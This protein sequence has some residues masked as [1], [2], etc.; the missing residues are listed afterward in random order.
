MLKKRDIIICFILG[1]LIFTGC[2]G[3]SVSKDDAIQEPVSEEIF[4]MDTYMTVTA[5]GK[6]AQDAV[7][8]AIE[9]IERLDA[10]LS[11]GDK[12]S[13]IS[14]LNDNGGGKV[15]DD[16][17]YLLNRS[18]ELWEETNGKFDITIYPI[19]L[20]WGFTDKNFTVPSNETLSQLLTL[21]DS[22]AINLNEN[23]S[24][25]TFEKEGLK[26][27]LGGIAKGYTSSRIMD[28]FRENGVTKGLVSLGG[29]VQVLG[30]KT[31]NDLW[32]VAIQNPD[33][34]DYLG[35]LQAEDC[36]VITSGG[37]ERYFEQDGITY[38]HIID[39]ATGYPANN[40]LKSVTIVSEDGTLADGLSTSLFIMGKDQAI[41]YWRKHIDEFDT[42]LVDDNGTIY[43]SEGI[44]D[45]FSSEQEIQIIKREG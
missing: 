23:K 16:T 29:N 28:I 5:Y 24:T 13:E 36:A 6:N 12:N 34:A 37:Y 40:G 30:R 20:S 25:V 26:I 42:I 17:K 45:R 22:S 14:S 19:M 27:D 33:G 4:A 3:E 38:H 8:K 31:D 35:V 11:T 41:D 43:V 9:E 21:V 44:A 2:S 15:S 39:P 18:L 10:L 7:D 32:R 1:C